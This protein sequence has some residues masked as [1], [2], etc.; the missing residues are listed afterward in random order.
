MFG[1]VP[2][3]H[4]LIT[5]DCSSVF[6]LNILHQVQAVARIYFTRSKVRPA[7][8]YTKYIAKTLQRDS[9]ERFISSSSWVALWSDAKG[10][11]NMK[12]PCQVIRGIARRPDHARQAEVSSSTVPAT[13]HLEDLEQAVQAS[14]LASVTESVSPLMVVLPARQLCPLWAIGGC[15]PREAAFP[16]VGHWWLSSPWGSHAPCG[17][18]GELSSLWELQGEA[19]EVP[20]KGLHAY[21]VK[22]HKVRYP[23]NVTKEPLQ[24]GRHAPCGPFVGLSS[25]WGSHAPCGPLC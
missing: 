21:P 9:P 19:R 12:L 3:A 16:P 2:W 17:P 7:Y 11:P 14:M 1:Y 8:S 4:D 15:P 20:G 6:S 22:R 23:V 24:W 5:L 25:P 13:T 18:F 10:T